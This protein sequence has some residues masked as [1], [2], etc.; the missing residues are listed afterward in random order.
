MWRRDTE[1]SRVKGCRQRELWFRAE[2]FSLNECAGVLSSFCVAS[3]EILLSLSL[4]LLFP[5]ILLSAPFPTSLLEHPS[6]PLSFLP[7]GIGPFPGAFLCF[8]SSGSLICLHVPSSHLHFCLLRLYPPLPLPF[9]LSLSLS[10]SLC[11]CVCVS[12]FLPYF[13]L[14]VSAPLSSSLSPLGCL[15][16]EV[17]SWPEWKVWYQAPP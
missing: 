14:S 12:S 5:F 2:I 15:C 7:V 9:Y 1:G 16:P 6:H 13:V 11:V 10:L 4:W 17:S 8:P 3:A